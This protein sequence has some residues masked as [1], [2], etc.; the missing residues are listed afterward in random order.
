MVVHI[1]LVSKEPELILADG[2]IANGNGGD[3]NGDGN[4]SSFGSDFSKLLYIL[5]ELY[6]MSKFLIPIRSFSTL[7]T[8][9]LL[10]W[11]NL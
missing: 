10:A 6:L 1:I 9:A 11:P 7:I 2:V 4:P 8:L 5:A 3:I